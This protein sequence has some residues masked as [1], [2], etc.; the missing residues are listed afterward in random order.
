VQTFLALGLCVGTKKQH[1]PKLSRSRGYGSDSEHALLAST[2]FQCLF[3]SVLG[4]WIDLTQ[5]GFQ[6][7]FKITLSI[8]LYNKGSEPG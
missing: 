3:A 6:D 5:K 2:N 1:I 8:F 4:G 7:N